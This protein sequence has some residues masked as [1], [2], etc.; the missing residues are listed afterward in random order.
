[1]FAKSALYLCPRISGALERIPGGLI[2]AI[3]SRAPFCQSTIQ[4]GPGFRSRTI[5][6]LQVCFRLGGV[7]LHPLQGSVNVGTPVG[8]QVCG[9]AMN[10]LG[11][12]APSLQLGCGCVLESLL[13]MLDLLA[14]SFD[15]FFHFRFKAV[16][17]VFQLT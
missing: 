2:G 3:K 6:L 12:I 17:I 13:L 9:C 10:L 4:G 14:E 11:C 7:S 8:S 5:Q 1:M 15:I 16:P